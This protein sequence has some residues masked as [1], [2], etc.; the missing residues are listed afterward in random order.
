M[1]L[2]LLAL[3]FTSYAYVHAQVD[4]LNSVI[5]S[6][7]HQWEAPIWMQKSAP[8]GIYSSVS[9]L[10]QPIRGARELQSSVEAG[11]I[12][13]RFSVGWIIT[14]YID[15]APQTVI[16]PDEYLFQFRYGMLDGGFA[17]FKSKHLTAMAHVAI[18]KGDIVWQSTD[19]EEIVFRQALWFYQPAIDL[20]YYPFN[21][22][23]IG[24]DLGYRG[25]S[26]ILLIGM[27]NDEL[28]GFNIGF[29]I[30]ISLI[31]E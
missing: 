15:A 31:Y 25:T 14:E 20:Y 26:E 6:A 9:C 16:F 8:V 18:G 23:G 7:D 17:L 5:D 2:T 29:G 24:V 11:I 30:Q 21:F 19:N 27:G 28:S 13:R 12:F 10:L 4:S 1:R 22:V 3:L